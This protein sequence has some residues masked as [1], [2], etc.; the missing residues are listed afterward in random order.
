[1]KISTLVLPARKAGDLEEALGQHSL[2]HD[3]PET[4]PD[5]SVQDHS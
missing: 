5:Q 1:M 4:L 2:E 3:F